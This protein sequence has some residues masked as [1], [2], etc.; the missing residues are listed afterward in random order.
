MVVKN[1][2]ELVVWQKSMDLVE[3][4][5]RASKQFPRDEIY[6]RT[7]QLR[8]AAVSV[9]SNIAEGQRRRSTADFVRFLSIGWGSLAELETQLFIADRLGYWSSD[10][11]DSIMLICEDVSKMFSALI[12]KLQSN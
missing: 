2:K 3:M 1:F 9:P 10:Q 11:L 8:R 5:Y 7:N 12:A 6:S 4:V